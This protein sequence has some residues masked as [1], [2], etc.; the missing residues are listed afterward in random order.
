MRGA[1]EQLAPTVGLAAACRA[2]GVSRATAYRHRRL[3]TPVSR[4]RRPSL[5]SL[6]PPE[7]TRVLDML[8][9]DRFV[10]R[11]PAAVYATLLVSRPQ[12]L[13]QSRRAHCRGRCLAPS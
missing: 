2:L 4:G 10:D 5:R 12:R 6:T 11:V 9:E 8:H 7:R 3:T 13:P 1:T